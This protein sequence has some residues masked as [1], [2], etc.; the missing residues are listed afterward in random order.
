[1]ISF[2][3][4]IFV[5]LRIYNYLVHKQT[6][7]KPFKTSFY[8]NRLFFLMSICCSSIAYAQQTDPVLARV[9]YTYINKADTIAQSRKPRTE[10]MLLFLG[11]NAALYT[12]YDKINYEIAEDQKNRARAM[13]RVSNNN[14]PTV[15]KIDRS[16]GEW[17][18]KTNY[19]SFAKE[20]KMYIKEN[21]SFQAYL[22]EAQIPKINWKIT[23]DTIT[24]SG[25][26][27]KQAIAN[28]EGKN[29]HAWFASDIPFQNGPWLL[30]GLPGLIIEAFSED[31]MI[32]FQFAGFEK[33]EAGDFKRSYDIRKSPTYTTGQISSVDAALGLDVAN[34]YFENSISLPTYQTIKTTKK[35]FEKL[36]A[37]QQKDPKGFMKAQFGF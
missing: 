34:A 22:M 23:K 33:A 5:V 2:I 11:K 1:M 27:C 26:A 15:V 18:S 3:Y 28:Y 12:S 36:K 6:P 35:E 32:Q 25:I 13:A 19:F 31:K 21:L 9:R 8:M 7:V 30:Q 20:Q 24:L 10:N 29:W 17:L 14:M 37:A 16:A 4:D